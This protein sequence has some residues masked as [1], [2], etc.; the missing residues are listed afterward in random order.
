MRIN[1]V[2]HGQGRKRAP[3]HMIR[4]R[5]IQ[6]LA[7]LFS[8]LVNWHCKVDGHVKVEVFEDGFEVVRIRSTRGPPLCGA[9]QTTQ[10]SKVSYGDSLH[11]GGER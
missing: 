6:A 9:L 1:A 4:E 7:I 11:H 2:L 8:P 5:V 3:E 10:A